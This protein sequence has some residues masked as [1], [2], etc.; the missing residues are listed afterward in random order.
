ML[1]FPRH[2]QEKYV[3]AGRLKQPSIMKARIIAVVPV[4]IVTSRKILSVSIRSAKMG[5]LGVRPRQ[6][7]GFQKPLPGSVK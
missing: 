6:G 5:P 4:T 2:K 7:I 3:Q 1:E